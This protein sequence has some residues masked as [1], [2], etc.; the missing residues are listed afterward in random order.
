VLS[1]VT[2]LL[3]RIGQ[4]VSNNNSIACY[5]T[6]ENSQTSK[7]KALFF[8]L[9]NSRKI[10]KKRTFVVAIDPKQLSSQ[11]PHFIQYT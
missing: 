9:K 11:S 3:Q 10:Y 7:K 8:D 2:L 6:P 5:F 1:G 4:M